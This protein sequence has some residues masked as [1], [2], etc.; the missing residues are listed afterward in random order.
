MTE[1]HW[2]LFILTRAKCLG[3]SFAEEDLKLLVDANMSKQ[4]AAGEQKA[5]NVLGV[6]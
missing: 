2:I 1:E 6:A 5:T 3:C 4:C